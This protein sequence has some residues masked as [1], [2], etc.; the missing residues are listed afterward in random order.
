MS[1]NQRQSQ[2]DDVIESAAKAVFK[3]LPG[4]CGQPWVEGGNSLKQDEARRYASAALSVAPAQLPKATD[5]LTPTSYRDRFADAVALLC[6]RRA[7]EDMIDGWLAPDSEDDRLQHFA[8]DHGPAWAQ[9]IVL[10]DAAAV[11]ADTPTE[12][13]EHGERQ[14]AAKASV[15]PL[16]EAQ[17]IH[18]RATALTIEDALDMA[19]EALGIGQST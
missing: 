18:I 10:L 8:A 13:V 4:W 1:T 6:G 5:W 17:R 19:E 15:E 14:A 3:T 12:G 16:T 9:G 11:M 2:P 7:P